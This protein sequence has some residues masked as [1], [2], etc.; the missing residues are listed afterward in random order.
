MGKPTRHR[1]EIKQGADGLATTMMPKKG[2]PIARVRPP[3]R[4]CISSR[5][6]RSQLRGYRASELVAVNARSLYYRR[7][8]YRSAASRLE[9]ALPDAGSDNRLAYDDET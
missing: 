6:N 1:A 3:S 7:A 9:Q 4:E 5:T 2:A 8:L